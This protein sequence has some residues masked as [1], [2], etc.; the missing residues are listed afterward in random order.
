M[1]PLTK[2]WNDIESIREAMTDKVALLLFSIRSIIRKQMR[3]LAPRL[4]VMH[5]VS[6]NNA[7]AV[8]L[9]KDL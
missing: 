1:G 3:S 8:A 5:V 4:K 6:V 7:A 2:L 9:A